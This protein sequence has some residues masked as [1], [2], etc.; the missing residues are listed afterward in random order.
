MTSTQKNQV[1]ILAACVVCMAVFCVNIWIEPN[2]PASPVGDSSEARRVGAYLGYYFV[3]AAIVA[4]FPLLGA[5]LWRR[6]DTHGQALLYRILSL[7]AWLAWIVF[8]LL[9]FSKWQ[10]LVKGG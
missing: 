4:F 1:A 5:W 3:P 8:L 7:G 9:T 10:L 6:P 2:Y